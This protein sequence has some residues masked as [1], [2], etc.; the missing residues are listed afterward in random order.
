MSDEPASLPTWRRPG[1]LRCRN[2]IVVALV[3]SVL[4]PSPLLAQS[5]S[6]IPTE[7][8]VTP[9]AA[10]RTKST[11]RPRDLGI[12]GPGDAIRMVV[13]SFETASI[14]AEINARITYLPKREGDRVRKGDVVASFDCRRIEAEHDAASA[15]LQSA[16]A[17]YETQRRLKR[18]EAAGTLAVDQA[19]YDVQKAEAEVRGLQAK[20]ATCTILAPFDARIVEK[21]ANTHEIAQANQP[22]VRL[23]NDRKVEL[24]LMVPSS[25][26]AGLAEGT[27]FDVRIDETGEVHRARILQ[28]TGLIDPVSQSARFIA[29]LAVGA[30]SVLPGMS[31]TAAF[32]NRGAAQ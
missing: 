6:P 2:R 24:V 1:F 8:Q 23:V 25:W 3:T 22:L 30:P 17:G 4:A 12:A 28:A 15:A 5:L 29:E 9:T 7:V 32:S 27:G 10:T 26:L 21:S 31:G 14:S 16:R 20:L 13:R 18:Y 19:K 11:E